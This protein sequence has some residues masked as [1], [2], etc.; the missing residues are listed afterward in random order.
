MEI[1]L[2]VTYSKRYFVD[3]SPA[4]G[5]AEPEILLNKLKVYGVQVGKTATMNEWNGESHKGLFLGSYCF[6]LVHIIIRNYTG[7]NLVHIFIDNYTGI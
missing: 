2:T 4:Y 6:N 3:L 5:C 7:F 1:A